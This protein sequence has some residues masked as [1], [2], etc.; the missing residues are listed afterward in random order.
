MKLKKLVESTPSIQQL[1]MLKLPVS[2][3]FKI[4]NFTK[5]ADPELKTFSEI[6]DNKIKELGELKKDEDGNE[7][8][9]YEVKKE[10]VDQYKKEIEELLDQDVDLYV[11]EIN[12]SELGDLKIEPAILAN[13]DWLIKE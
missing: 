6:R 11:P 4:A 3:S 2:V 1:A 9:D 12:L 7:T 13:L 8:T 10:N 5:K